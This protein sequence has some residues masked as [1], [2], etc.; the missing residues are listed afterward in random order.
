MDF[1][2]LDFETADRATT[3]PCEL[4]ITFVTNGQLGE[5]K[6]W[7]IRPEPNT[8]DYFNILLHGIRP[9]TVANEPV[10]DVIW[11]EV[12]PLLEGQFIIAHNAGFD[13]GVLRRSLQRRSVPLPTFD[14]ACSRI[15]SKPV[16]PGQPSYGLKELCTMNGIDFKHHR[17]GPDSRAT[18][19]L[20]I[21]AFELAEIEGPEDFP[22][23]LK[24]VVGKLFPDGYKPCNTKSDK[25]FWRQALISTLVADPTKENPESIFHGRNVVFTGALSSMTRTEAQQTIIDIG[26]IA[27]GT[28]TKT[29]DFLVV[30][31]QDYRLVG[32]TGM[33]SKQ[34]KAIKMKEDGEGIEI[35]SEADFVQNL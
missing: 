24:T 4:G 31:Q 34:K 22:T 11:E 7:L 20:A 17:A 35:L 29:T 32:E 1:I 13:I 18:A 26:G 15:F 10:F 16:W 9:E 33:S 2:T 28:V 25:S 23:K 14:Y 30:G 19:E 8:F 6:S 12:R 5:T 27:T 3:S 21:R